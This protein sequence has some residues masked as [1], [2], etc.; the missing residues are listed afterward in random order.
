MAKEVVSSLGR[1]PIVL[2]GLPGA[3]KSSIGPAL[4]RRLGLAF[5]DSDKKIE[6]VTGMSFTEI[7]D[8]KTKAGS[9]SGTARRA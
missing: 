5:V 7:L 1:R 9:G 8:A 6:R 2:V 3:G 4:A